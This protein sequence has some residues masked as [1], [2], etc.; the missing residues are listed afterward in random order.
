MELGHGSNAER[1]G[2]SRVPGRDRMVG[3]ASRAVRPPYSRLHGAYRLQSGDDVRNRLGWSGLRARTHPRSAVRRC[4]ERAFRYGPSGAVDGPRRRTICFGDER[5]RP[6]RRQSRRALQR[7]EYLLG[8]A[9]LVALSHVRFR[10]CS[11]A[12]WRIAKV[13]ARE[14]RSKPAR[15][16]CDRQLNSLCA[17]N[18]RS[19]PARTRSGPRSARARFA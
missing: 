14:G 11:G 7:P 6:R 9:R 10:W 2:P 8:D 13:G 19:W 5:P 4:P 17:D 18:A 16:D 1:F 15:P 12:E 3:G